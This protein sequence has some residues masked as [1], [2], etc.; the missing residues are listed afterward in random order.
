[1]EKLKL[2]DKLRDKAN[3]SY[4]EAK[5]TLEHSQW[6]ILDA[7]LYLESIGK[8][9]RPQVGIFYTNENEECN[10]DENEIITI[11]EE[12]NY[13]KSSYRSSFEGIFEAICKAIDTCNNI[14][15]E[16]TT[17]NKI[18]LKIPLTVVIILLFFGFWIIVP[19]M[20]LGLFFQLRY[21][22]SGKR[23]N[24]DKVNKAFSDVAKAAENIKK[25]F[26]RRSNNDKNSNS[27]R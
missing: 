2:I 23:V 12:N 18:L 5:N 26:T 9:E 11:N 19:L 1:M 21:K 13:Q 20:I 3:I 4:E 15:F 6:D 10:I 25:K 24:S 17:N 16:V 8:V 27:R 14:F 22:I 7:M